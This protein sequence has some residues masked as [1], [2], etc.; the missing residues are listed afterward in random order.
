MIE[1]TENQGR[2]IASALTALSLVVVAGVVVGAGWL[3]V[4]A[5]GILAPAIVPLVMG[6]FLAMFF[7]PYYF[8]WLRLVKNPSLAVML[9][10]L[11]VLVPMG[12]LAWYF[13]SFA[14]AQIGGL[15]ESAPERAARV[16]EWFNETFPNAKLLAD[17]LEIPYDTW[18]DSIKEAFVSSTLG[19]AGYMTSVLNWL[20]SL[21]FF[22]Y[23]VT[24]P[25]FTG[26]TWVRE[27]PF[28]KE[29]TRRFVAT[30]ID[31][32]FDIIV[33][34]FQ[35]QVVI[36]LLEGLYYG[37]GFMLVG[38]PYGFIVGFALGVLNLVPLFGTLVC[39]PIALPLAY[40]GADGS[41]C[42]VACVIAV[43]LVGQVMDG[44]FIT[45]KIQGDK[46]GLGYAGVIFSF[47]FWSA[48]FNSFLGLL[49][50]IPL[51]A[52]WVV[53]WRALKSKYIK[54]VV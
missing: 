48:V 51:S 50:A 11:S 52:F 43:W 14:V 35:R 27:M 38:L 31:A 36:C 15:V 7:R 47:F 23:F 17:R 6:L 20:V 34:F 22:V 12:L 42:R 3:V 28:L 1:F 30:H 5:L 21:I 2:T 54:P 4:K 16:A 32:F 8:L 33:S 40:W 37:L 13:G 44:Y 10:L 53:L 24:R 49:L 9:M 39:L 29:D 45:P 18:A 26:E 46:T 41:T 19:F 25:A